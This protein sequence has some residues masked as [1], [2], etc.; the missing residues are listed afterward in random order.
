MQVFA[1]QDATTVARFRALFPTPTKSYEHDEWQF[2]KLHKIIIGLHGGDL[3]LEIAQNLNSINATDFTGKSALT[4]AA[5]KGNDVAVKLLLKANADPNLA[6]NRGNIALFE[7]ARYNSVTCAKLLLAANANVQHNNAQLY[8]ALHCAAELSKSEDMIRLLIE[9]GASINI[10]NIY[11][12]SPLASTCIQDNFI[13]ATTLLNLGAS[14]DIQDYDGDTPLYE[15]LLRCADRVTQLL[16]QRGACYTRIASN[17]DSV[18]HLAAKCG[19]TETLNILIAAELTGIDPYAENRDGKTATR[20][21]QERSP[22]PPGFLEKIYELIM[23][24]DTRN[25]RLAQTPK[26]DTQPSD[27]LKQQT[28][29]AVPPLVKTP[30][31]SWDVALSLIRRCS[32]QAFLPSAFARNVTRGRFYQMQ[33]IAQSRLQQNP[34]GGLFVGWAISIITAAII[35]FCVPPS[36]EDLKGYQM[37]S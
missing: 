37:E 21:A 32:I 19:G 25:I 17:G 11:G 34:F 13:A 23:G 2:S 15:A 18:L 27:A 9:A 7:A 14:I 10:R 12:S 3:K 20:I 36:R 31:T 4:W 24:I 1:S 33:V 6:D 26:Q 8:G 29:R 30:R 35:L 22:R 16:L 28:A 5:L